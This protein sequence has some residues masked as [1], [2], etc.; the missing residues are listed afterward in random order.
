MSGPAKR[1]FIKE[2]L[3]FCWGLG[4]DEVKLP[5]IGPAILNDHITNPTL[6]VITIPFGHKNYLN[7]KESTPEKDYYILKE[8]VHNLIRQDLIE[9]ID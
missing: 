1:I 2:I 3:R 7:P 5:Y 9:Y 4:P 8:T 6:C